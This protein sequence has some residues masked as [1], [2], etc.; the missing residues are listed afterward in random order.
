[1]NVDAPDAPTVDV[2]NGDEV[3]GTAEPGSTITVS[4]PDGS[5]S[6]TMVDEDGT[7]SIST[8]P[9]MPSGDLTATA[10]DP[11][12]NTSGQTKV[13][14]DTESPQAPV[15]EDANGDR[16]AGTA[17]PGSTIEV[18][19]PDGSTSSTV[20][21][22]DGSWSVTTPDDM[23]SGTITVTATDPSG[24][25]SPPV[26]AE[27]DTDPPAPPVVDTANGDQVTGT[28]EPGSTV[29]VN[30]P[31]GSVTTT[32]AD[33]DGNWSV[34]TAPD[35]PSGEIEVWV[36]DQA[37]NV[38]E[39]TITDLDTQ[40]PG[41]PVIE[42]ANGDRVAGTGEPGSTVEVTWPDGST[43]S[44]VVGEDGSWSVST[45][46]D[47]DSGTIS[48]T[49]TDPSGNTSEPRTAELD[50]EAP[51]APVI[52]NANG[53][54]V[55]GTAEPG[56]TVEVTWPDG[57]TSSTVVGEDGRWS[58]STP[59]DMESGTLTATATDPSGNTSGPRSVQLN[60]EAP[61]APV[62]D[63]ANGDEVTGTAE[64]GSEITVS[65]P[66]GST[67]TTT[68]D[69][70]GNWTISTPPDMP[71]GDLTV[72]ATDPDGNTSGQTKLVLDTDPPEAPV[73]KDAN[74]DQVAGTAEPGSTI[75]VTW[76]D[77]STSSTV[78]G[79]DGSW[80][81]STPDDMD[82]GTITV[83]ATDPSG[84]TS[85]PVSSL[86]DTTGPTEPVVESAN[87]AEVAGTAEPGSTVEVT[88]PDGSTSQVT[89]GPD[90]QWRVPTPDSVPSGDI[91]VTATDPAGNPSGTVRVVLDADTPEP[92]VVT[93]ANT[94][95]VTGTAEPGSIVTLTWPD[96]STT[97][98][99]ADAAGR[100]S[101]DNPHGVYGEQVTLTATDPVGN[102]SGPR[103]ITIGVLSIEIEHAQLRPGEQQVIIGLAFVPGEVV[104]LMLDIASWQP[105]TGVADQN[106]TVTFSVAIPLDYQAGA[107]TATLTGSQSG[108]VASSFQILTPL[109]VS[110]GGTLTSVS[111]PS[112]MVAG[113]MVLAGAALL[114]RS[115]RRR[116]LITR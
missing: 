15:I 85:D 28:A 90:G 84:N 51:E 37:G 110:T 107:R 64:P 36:T 46:D 111:A 87:G 44:T 114:W 54:Q 22:E 112:V 43:S 96:G 113:L 102:V 33:P 50:A 83:T 14:L 1:L 72:T 81:V 12:G 40:A 69:E 32:T 67:S 76:P 99:T 30:W 103:V 48:V 77:G 94:A 19:W 11:D 98:A 16:V 60:T 52:D 92:P 8:P 9:D 116:A 25:S 109:L 45:P 56:S 82:S 89:T 80:S 35:V 42:D 31:D 68:V 24:N 29:T 41:S 18:S 86:L 34:A 17:E 26:T 79:E 75:E 62:V 38:S 23:D 58:V 49:V 78:V 65:W 108:T 61:D 88:W 70:D 27:L 71:S 2:A 20:V 21:G 104:T 4:W 97:T 93:A 101:V 73:I 5:S 7:W 10:T 91:T 57:S 3:A 106:G 95:V 63:V 53:H 105:L 115:T 47:M 13:V 100:W 6:S 55:A 59:E 74:G 66:D 39:P